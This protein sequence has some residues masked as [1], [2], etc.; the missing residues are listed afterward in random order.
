[1]SP[2]GLARR[3]RRNVGRAGPGSRVAGAHLAAARRDLVDAQ[4]WLVSDLKPR[5]WLALTLEPKSVPDSD[6]RNGAFRNPMG[7]AFRGPAGHAAVLSEDVSSGC[8]N[9]QMA[10]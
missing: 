9:I 7:S 4:P 5:E 6:R 3:S 2:A 1:M 8:G 10:V